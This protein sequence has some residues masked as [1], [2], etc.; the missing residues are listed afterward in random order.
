MKSLKN[1]YGDEVYEAVTTALTAMNQYNP[2]GRYP[3]PELWN[4]K[5]RRKATLTE[6]VSYLLKQWKLHR[7]KR[8]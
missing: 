4:P 6:G 3:V 5:E 2:S 7:R 8:N 1:E